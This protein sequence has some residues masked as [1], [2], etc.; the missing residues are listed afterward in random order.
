MVLPLLV[1]AVL[2]DAGPLAFEE[3]VGR[4]TQAPDV[5]GARDAARLQRKLAGEVPWLTSNPTVLLQPQARTERGVGAGAEF[6]GGVTQAF[7]L[8][9]LGEARREGALKEAEAAEVRAAV[10]ALEKR[11]AAA[12]AWLDAWG[13]QATAALAAEEEAAAAQLV[14]HLERALAAGGATRTELAEAQAFAAEATLEH[15]D[16]EGR[17][18]E[19]SVRL[20]TTLGM[21]GLPAAVS[22]QLP[23]IR[24]L[25]ELPAVH[26]GDV[27]ASALDVR[28]SR[29]L[30]DEER[31]RAAETS[32]QRGWQVQ[33]GVGGAHEF[34]DT[35]Y[36]YAGAT[37]TLPAWDL[38]QRELSLH[39]AEV[40]RREA[41]A[42]ARARAWAPRLAG[43]R[44]ECEHAREV[45]SVVEQ[46]LLPAARLAAEHESALFDR[47]EST[48]PALLRVRRLALNARA[49]L[50]RARAETVLADFNYLELHRQ[51]GPE[52]P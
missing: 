11:L 13:A 46:R 27:T 30:A 21:E 26:G 45:L 14:P 35:W 52:I 5:V 48:L 50:L 1:A 7:N 49:R 3:A 43:L 18:V 23:A 32:A 47:G 4:A 44:H 19:A 34:P 38:G 10:L 6:Q 15:L 28:A 22:S 9:G 39:R 20:G 40:R 36:G 41:E 2:A 12:A 29:A 16:Q 42:E 51:L 33:V 37:V 25:E 31:A 17:R 8:S 24:P